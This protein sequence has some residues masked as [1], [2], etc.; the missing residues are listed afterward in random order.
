MK[1]FTLK[2]RFILLLAILL[3][4][5]TAIGS[6]T[7]LSFQKIAYINQVGDWVQDLETNM[8]ELRQ[9]E[10][11]FVARTITDPDFYITGESQYTTSFKDGILEAGN[12]C[13]QL[14]AS[15][16]ISEE[17]AREVALI[18]SYLT[19]YEEKFLSIQQ[20]YKALGYKNWGLIGEMRTFIHEVESEVKALG[21]D[22][23]Q[24][25]MLAL[26]RSEKDFLL[27][28][29]LVYKENFTTELNRF[30]QTLSRLRLSSIQ[31]ESIKNSL[32]NYS[33]GFYNLIDGKIRIGLT[34]DT[35]LMGEMRAVIH[36]VEPL[37]MH[38]H[39]QVKMMASDARRRAMITLFTFF[40]LGSILVMGIVI[41]I[42]RQV[43]KQLGGDPRDVARLAEEIA[44]GNLAMDRV[45]DKNHLGVMKSMVEM[46]NKL[47]EMISLILSSSDEIVAAGKQLNRTSE[48]ISQSA[49]EQA[50]GV[51]EI[52]ST[53][54]EINSNIHQN[55]QNAKQ[56]HGIAQSASDGINRVNTQSIQAL[57][58]NRLIVEKIQVIND[59]AMQTNILALNAAVEAA[60]AGEQG[61][62][63]AVVA[64]EVR[65]LAERSKAA[66]DDIVESA[67]NS[68]ILAENSNG[69]LT[70]MLPQIERTTQ[71]VMEITVASQEQQSG[72]EQVNNAIQQL[73]MATQE[74]ASVSEE[75]AA[76]SKELEEQ[77]IRLKEL[78]SYFKIED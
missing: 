53:V 35:G 60:R 41:L 45:T 27:R 22:R 26:R 67:N 11:D 5:F 75:M 2:Q 37:V 9:S 33:N 31:K 38:V 50:S 74:N 12:V 23:A 18:Q 13:M 63:F 8:L 62:G 57:D 52:S 56:T 72:V 77:A 6:F 48:Q 64:G 42:V 34:E 43:F 32:E 76:S 30:Y 58:A 4:A 47:K 55:N 20:V 10:K 14:L 68:L 36:Q 17:E 59:I 78:V 73:N 46:S 61:K 19:E 44:Q 49:T 70:I 51:E 29:D 16:T 65:K 7:Y 15:G 69:E 1:N 71:L 40:V 66:A 54:E 3:V 24:V 21:L 28:K 25:H 39:D